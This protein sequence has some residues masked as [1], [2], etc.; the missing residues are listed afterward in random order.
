M[1][2]ICAASPEP[3]CCPQC[4]EPT[5][6]WLEGNCPGCLIQLAVPES[7]KAVCDEAEAARAGII[8]MLGDYELLAEIARGGMGVV[9]RA[10]QV[11]LNRLVAVKVLL[12]PQFGRDTQRFRREAEVAAGLRHP[13]IVSIHEVGEQDGQPYFSMELIEGRNLAEL[14]REQPPGARRAASITKTIAEAVQYAH[15]RHLLHGH[16]KP[17]NVL[18]DDAGVPHVTDF[19]L[20]K[21]S[22][23]DA[24]LT[25]AGQVVGTPSYMPPGA[26]GSRGTPWQCGGR[27]VFAGGDPL[28]T[29]DQQ[30]TFPCGNPHANVAPRR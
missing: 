20:A 21:R 29:A 6:G 11:S 14:S 16:V 27:C 4:G 24:D 19:G 10:R 30:R 26:G 12:A 8:G 7:G 17:S 5:S 23:G 3:E 15:E 22:D 2:E 1:T 25:L 13:N 9:Y 28:P 18:V